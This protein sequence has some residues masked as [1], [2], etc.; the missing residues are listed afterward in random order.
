MFSALQSPRMT[1]DTSLPSSIPIILGSNIENKLAKEK[2]T[3]SCLDS[4]IAQVSS[5]PV[6]VDVVDFLQRVK[7]CLPT[8]TQHIPSSF[9]AAEKS[10]SGPSAITLEML[11]GL[12]Q[13]L[14]T[15]FAARPASFCPDSTVTCNGDT[16]SAF[17]EKYSSGSSSYEGNPSQQFSMISAL[18]RNLPLLQWSHDEYSPMFSGPFLSEPEV[19]PPNWDT[20][21]DLQRVPQVS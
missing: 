13:V 6:L 5:L 15:A 11:E 3:K 20:L 4:D 10:N 7:P 1:H 2:E 12:H 9:S 19:L 18:S 17:F 14:H 16:P 8:Q 21:S